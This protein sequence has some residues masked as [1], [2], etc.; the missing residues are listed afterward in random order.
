MTRF[1]DPGII[2]SHVIT[3]MS[4]FLKRNENVT[5]IAIPTGQVNVVYGNHEQ[6]QSLPEGM[7]TLIADSRYLFLEFI[8]H[9]DKTPESAI[10]YLSKHFPQYEELIKRVKISGT[11]VILA[12]L[13]I[14]GALEHGHQETIA[15]LETLAILGAAFSY[16]YLNEKR[17]ARESAKVE[18]ERKY[19]RRHILTGALVAI[20]SIWAMSP[21]ISTT[22]RMLSVKTGVGHEASLEFKKLSNNL[23]PENFNKII[24]TLR[25]M[26]MAYKLIKLFENAKK[27]DPT[28]NPVATLVLGATH[29]GIEDIFAD[30]SSGKLTI[31]MMENALNELREDIVD[32]TYGIAMG[33][34]F[35]KEKN[36][37]QI[38]TIQFPELLKQINPTDTN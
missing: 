20:G 16:E 5:T 36:A 38:R 3:N 1:T 29:V 4:E 13:F 23:H 10:D 22:S 32:M 35:D 12:D 27:M 25:E 17:Q 28:C 8:D 14:E 31:E 26:V 21:Q 9:Y 18:N 7:E 33:Y 19:T 11:E 37:W 6:K 30:Y 2:D 15:I 24:M 34:F